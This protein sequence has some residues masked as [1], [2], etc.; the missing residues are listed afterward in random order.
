MTSS[1]Y[2][3][4]LI[5][6]LHRI[7]DI[8]ADSIR[9][10]QVPNWPRDSLPKSPIV[11]KLGLIVISTLHPWWLP[12]LEVSYEQFG[13]Y[14][15]ILALA[16]EEMLE[17][18]R[19]EVLE[20]GQELVV[21]PTSLEERMDFP[22]ISEKLLNNLISISITPVLTQFECIEMF[23]IVAVEHNLLLK[24]QGI[25]RRKLFL[26]DHLQ[27]RLVTRV[28][29]RMYHIPHL[30]DFILDRGI[31]YAYCF[32][33]EMIEAFYEALTVVTNSKM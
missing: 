1:P 26:G 2:S 25:L 7:L 17:S 10:Q 19:C 12:E 18:G 31:S 8:T 13:P 15:P 3:T 16:F 33:K 20:E 27:E 21:Q 32:V 11:Q 29:A 4:E 14:S 6:I 30:N 9:L 5:P 28:I 23:S 24:K 22:E